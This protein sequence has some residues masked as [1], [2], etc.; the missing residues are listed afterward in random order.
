MIFWNSSEHQ[1]LHVSSS[2]SVLLHRCFGLCC[3][4]SVGHR[5]GCLRSLAEASYRL[6]HGAYIRAN[7]LHMTLAKH[8]HWQKRRN[9]QLSQSKRETNKNN[10][11]GRGPATLFRMI[12]NRGA[13]ISPRLI[14]DIDSYLARA[15][16]T[17]RL[18]IQG[19]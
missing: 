18:A 7:D 9:V 13:G 6:I 5:V 8:R 19:P 1:I 17:T 4:L 3:R 15:F 10:I 14:W 16:Q 11:F 2:K 12:N